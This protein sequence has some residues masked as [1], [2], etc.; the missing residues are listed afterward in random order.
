MVSS[1][2]TTMKDVLSSERNNISFYINDV[3]IETQLTDRFYYYQ[4]KLDDAL[5]KKHMEYLRTNGSYNCNT[6]DDQTTRAIMGA[7]LESIVTENISTEPSM[8]LIH[9]TVS[10]LYSKGYESLLLNMMDYITPKEK[11][12]RMSTY[13]SSYYGINVDDVEIVVKYDGK[14]SPNKLLI[15]I[16][17]KDCGKVSVIVRNILIHRLQACY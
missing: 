6:N 16:K 14:I 11:Y 4:E 13:L 7:A 12:T 17:F 10:Y 9:H 3:K 15:D 8:C 1:A 2:D 5:V